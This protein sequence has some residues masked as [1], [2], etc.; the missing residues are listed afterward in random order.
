M[1]FAPSSY[2]AYIKNFPKSKVIKVNKN[3][4]FVLS[5][6]IKNNTFANNLYYLL[7]GKNV[8]E[9]SIKSNIV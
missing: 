6:S 1:S 5:P 2:N 8:S 7:S 3:G 9:A 4:E